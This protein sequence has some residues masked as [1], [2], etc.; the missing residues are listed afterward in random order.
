MPGYLLGF[1]VGSS[2]IKASLLNAET[3]RS[4]ASATAP[5]TEM[6]ISAPQ[7]GWAEQDPNEWWALMKEATAKI[8]TSAP[9]ELAET[10]A[11]GIAYQMHGLVIVDAD[12]KTLRPSIIWCDSRAVPYG[13]AAF[14][15]LGEERCLSHLLNS[16]GN[17]TAAKLAW[18]K[19]NEPDIFRRI[20][21][22]MLPGDYLAYRMTGEAVTTPSGL[23]EGVFWDFRD[24]SPA[25]F[26]LDHFGF[27]DEL[28]PSIKPSFAVH[29]HVTKHAAEELGI[30]AGT[31]VSY[32]AGD[33]P[34]NAFSL[35]VL[36]PGELAAT[37]GTSGVVYGIVDTPSYDPKSRV[38]T[39]VHVNHAREAAR[40]GVLLCVNG[41]GILNKWLKQNTVDSSRDSA[42]GYDEVN[43]IAAQ[44]PVGSLGLTFLP[45]GNGAERTLENV[46]IQSSLHGLNFNI[47]D[48]RHLLRAGQ[49]GIV[50]SLAYGVEIMR[51]MGLEVSTVKAGDA[52]MFLSPVF[53][54]AFATTTG[55]HVGLY[56]TD[57]SLGAARGAGVGAGRFSSPR[58]A[59]VGL[60]AVRTI[61]PDR[62]TADQYAEAFGVWKQKLAAELARR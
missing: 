22:V 47:H 9:K 59:F 20:W 19:E 7:P 14:S 44:A 31:P 39:F 1:D 2:S 11:I 55:T 17:F 45:F 16:P 26:L 50:F 61:E 24:E 53:G 38:N 21:K 41:T 49:E 3:G 12:G 37:A 43:R 23:S 30:P 36:E 18:V 35:N 48:R 4:V 57:G 25:S 32:R 34:N 13:A 29:G 51:G 52:N 15:A 62:G 8:R 58:D 5:E 28:L 56:N 6:A 42:V 46:E 27:D 60:E 40:Y 54:D 10:E 33:Q